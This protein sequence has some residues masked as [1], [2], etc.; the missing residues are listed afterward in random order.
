VDRRIYR[1]G[2]R[3]EAITVD[4]DD[5]P[6]RVFVGEPLAVGLY[7]SGVEVLGRSI[8]YH[9]PRSFFCLRGH[10]GG[11]LMRVN[12]LPNVRACQIACV[13]GMTAE[14]QNAFPSGE[15]D[16]LGAVDWF[17]PRGMD[18]H[19]LMAGSK[20]LHG[21]MQKVV[22]KLSGLGKLP[23]PGG[24]PAPMIP[25]GA[26]EVVD[27]VVIGAGPAGLA[28][29]V[30]TAQAG[31][32]TLV[33]DEQ[34]EPGGSWLSWPG[35]AAA[36]TA[37]IDALMAA[38]GTIWSQSSALSWFPEDDGGVL[39]VATPDRL[40]RITAQRYIYATGAYDVNLAFEDND[41]PGVMS[42]RALGL[43]AL[44][45]GVIPGPRV[46]IVG[47]GEYTTAL[48]GALGERGVEVLT[49]DAE[50]VRRARGGKS[51]D[52]LDYVDAAGKVV[53][54]NCDAV[55]VAGLPAPASEAAR[56]HG[57][58][59]VL[60]PAEGGFAVIVDGDG[61]TSAPQVV[62][63]GDVTGYQGPHAAA[64]EG[65]HVGATAAAEIVAERTTP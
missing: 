27:V 9:R 30:A 37:Q 62:A 43:L 11:C 31:L 6:H 58:R 39:A 53:S 42:A 57:A 23:D 19:R 44:R 59:V 3:G 65:A 21:A 55:A 16:L 33:V 50:R 8:K 63:C 26:A 4:V 38:G 60:D 54:F 1:D 61:H 22:R 40:V 48:A 35:G 52:A 2:D 25:A 15:Y 46:A 20:L 10:C 12:G 5:K 17:F 56:T 18:H 41:R 24:T 45:D 36:A 51:V 64:E 7:A 29:A 47:L 32:T 49:V 28:A 14:S 13:E 34:L